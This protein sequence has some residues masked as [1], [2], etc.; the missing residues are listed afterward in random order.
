[1]DEKRFAAAQKLLDAAQ[2]FWEACQAEGQ[3]GAVQWLLGSGGELLVY[4]RGEYRRQLMQ[5][6]D[7]LSGVE[8][9][10]KFG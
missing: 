6:I 7:T 1:M 2:E 8:P 4:T 9:E 3:Y 5:N 10:H